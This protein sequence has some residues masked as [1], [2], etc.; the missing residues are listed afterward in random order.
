[1]SQIA[2][3]LPFFHQPLSAASTQNNRRAETPEAHPTMDSQTLLNGQR[4]CLIHHGDVV[5]RLR[6]TR[7]DKLILTK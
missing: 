6:H 3:A 5:Y 1:M 7:N 2:S 4:E